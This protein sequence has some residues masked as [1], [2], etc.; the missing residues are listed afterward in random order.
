MEIRE[1]VAADWPLIWPFF[2]AIA[3]AGETFT[4]DR[5]I[6][7]ERG[8]DLWM[9]AAPGKTVVAVDGAA[10]LG[11]AKMNP[12]QGGPG[13]HV[14]S[15]SFMVDPRHA[16]RG[17]GGALGEYACSWARESGYR[18]MQFNAVVATNARAVGLWRSLGFAVIGT[19][20]E[21]FRHPVHGYV[22]L[23]IMHRTL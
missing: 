9:L 15:A 5:D 19:A 23:L 3:A 20:P 13:S 16:G 7:P 11:T 12:N 10:I 4:Y 2:R 17:I 1:A 22:D 6:T 8:R 14:A 21:A 18:A